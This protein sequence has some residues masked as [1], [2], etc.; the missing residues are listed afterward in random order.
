MTLKKIASEM[1]KIDFEFGDIFSDNDTKE[2]Y[3]FVGI[4]ANTLMKTDYLL[5]SFVN[6]KN[7]SGKLF[8]LDYINNNFTKVV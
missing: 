2:I 1:A 4:A 6:T 3:K 8:N 5:L 7:N